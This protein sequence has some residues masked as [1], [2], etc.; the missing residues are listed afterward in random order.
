MPETNLERLLKAGFIHSG[1][2]KLNDDGRAYPCV[3][4]ERRAGVYVYALDGEICYIGSAQR[5]LQSRFK[6]YETTERLRTAMRIRNEI[7][8]L[9][10]AGHQVEIYTICPP[11]IEWKNLPIDLIAGLEEGLIRNFNPK[12]NRRGRGRIIKV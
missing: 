11:A 12:W 3:E 8:P 6:H 9:L 1:S 5:G 2:W 10:Q 4:R 7:T